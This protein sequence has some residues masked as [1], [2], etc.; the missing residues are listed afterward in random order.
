MFS[1]LADLPPIEREKIFAERR[2]DPGLRAEVESLL[3]FDAS[4]RRLLTECVSKAAEE[5]LRSNEAPEFTHCGPYRLIRLLGSGG[6]GDVYLAE[7][8]DGEI[9]QQVAIKLLRPRADRPAWRERFLNERQLLASL[10]HPAIARVIDAGGAGERHPYLVMEFVDGQPV[11]EFSA[12]KDL[13]AQLDLFLAVCDAVS[14]AHQRLIIHR[15]LK[16]SNILV[17]ASGR[18]KLLDFGIAKLLD[19]ESEPTQTVERLLTPG[20]ASPEQLRSGSQTTATDIYSL[21]AVLYKM[22]TGRSPHESDDPSAKA[23]DVITGAREIPPARRSNPNLPDDIDFILR[24]ALRSEPEERYA[25]VEAFA[26]DIRAFLESRPVQ[27]RSGDIWYRARKFMRRYWLPVAA[28]VVTIAGLSVGLYVANRERAIAQR[29]FVQVRRL[30]NRV[31]ALDDQIGGLPGAAK[32][33]HEIVE[34]SKEYLEALGAEAQRDQDLALEIANAYA[35]LARSQGLPTSPNLG[36]YAQAEESLRK[37]EA[38]LDPVL[39]A[40]PQNRR[41]LL[42]SARISSNRM[43]LANTEERRAD[44][45]AHAG[46]A[47]WRLDTLLGL[48]KTSLTNSE[49]SLSLQILNNV[50]LTQKN[51][52]DFEGA[53]RSA[54]RSIEFSRSQPSAAAYAATAWSII[55]D[56]LRMSGD[57]DGALHAI[58]EARRGLEGADFRSQIRRQAT[59]FSVLWRE[60]VILGEYGGVNLNR[61]DEAIEVLRRAFDLI[62]EW[63]RADPNDASRRV[64]FAQGGAALGNLLRD[65]DPARALEVYDHSLL[66]LGEVKNNIRARRGEAEMLAYSSYA[67]RRLNLAR[68]AETRIARAFQ[69]LRQTKDYPAARIKPGSEADA[70]LRALADHHAATGRPE[71][72]AE[73]YRELLEKILASNPDPR[74]DLPNAAILSR[75]YEGLGAAYRRNRQTDKAEEQSTLRLELW[76]HWQRK[77]PNNSFIARQLTAANFHP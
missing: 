34:M 69:L 29:R 71:R 64:L 62:D 15:D 66:R 30:A 44:A 39:Q 59:W 24:K 63:A 27:A 33:R 55:A 76:R 74:N 4:Q 35:L 43:I 73:V 51:T 23:I 61:P 40:A 18:P 45:S 54:R 68:E 2:V 46:K 53:I 1:E 22:L 36:Q 31:L 77:L 12:G 17:D 57:L 67:L 37:A 56:S 6:M 52:H 58:R 70:A 65:R 3:R 5:T 75:T 26:N 38:L 8:A 25:S 14:H 50:A 48:G 32:A 72:A 13:R 28:A 21:G 19:E 10:N 49:L 41:A 16:P 11:D 7:R 42:A 47:V 60:G 20:Y 9:Q